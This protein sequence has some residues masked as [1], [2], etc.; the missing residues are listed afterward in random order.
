MKLEKNK[1]KQN[2]RTTAKTPP[3][4]QICGVLPSTKKYNKYIGTKNKACDEKER[5][6]GGGERKKNI[7]RQ[8]LERDLSSVQLLP[9]PAGATCRRSFSINPPP[10]SL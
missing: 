9:P 5:L 2:S 6:E 10:R 8:T 4:T 1:I 7:H 3:I